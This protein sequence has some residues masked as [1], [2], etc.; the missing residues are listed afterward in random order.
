MNKITIDDK[1]YTIKFSNV[2]NMLTVEFI[3]VKKY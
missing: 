3:G 2:N 1:K